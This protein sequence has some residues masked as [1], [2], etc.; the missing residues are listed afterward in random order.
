MRNDARNPKKMVSTFY[1]DDFGSKIAFWQ[2][3]V[4]KK[5]SAKTKVIRNSIYLDNAYTKINK[6]CKFHDQQ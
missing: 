3:I 2:D 4:F 5:K 1:N 6:S